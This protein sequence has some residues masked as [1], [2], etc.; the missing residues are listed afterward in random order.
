MNEWQE[1]GKTFTSN[2]HVRNRSRWAKHLGH[3]VG[4]ET[5]AVE[6]GSFEGLS[7]CWMMDH[8]ILSHPQSTMV[9]IDPHTYELNPKEHTTFLKSKM[10]LAQQRFLENT[11][12]YREAG[13][14]EYIEAPSR[15][16]L[17]ALEGPF[18][19][20]YIDGLHHTLGVLSDACLM[21]PLIKEGG[22]M[23]F[24]DYR[25]KKNPPHIGNPRQAIDA[26]LSAFK[27][28]LKVIRKDNQVFVRKVV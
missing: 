19:V 26:F 17:V 21:W 24:D 1:N 28:Q 3:L 6:V 8:I 25:W 20:G 2:W 12:E 9:C 7:A 13:R 14:M 11:R 16:A 4:K 23:M 10:E 27:N 15:T 5:H 22:I 18:D